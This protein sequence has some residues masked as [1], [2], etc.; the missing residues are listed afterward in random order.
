M[1]NLMSNQNV[2]IGIMPQ[3]YCSM[4]INNSTEKTCGFENSSLSTMESGCVR[5]CGDVKIELN[6]EEHTHKL[7]T[8]KK[9]FGSLT[10]DGTNLTKIDFLDGLESVVALK[11]IN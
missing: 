7:S 10:M 9:I 1:A 3:S 2:E 8:V 11:G 5:V 4:G 6:D